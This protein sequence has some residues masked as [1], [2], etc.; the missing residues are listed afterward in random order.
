[1]TKR[2]IVFGVAVWAAALHVVA[3]TEA[4]MDG[5]GGATVS[6]VQDIAG[7]NSWPM[8][9][10]VGGKLVCA[11]SR[12]SAHTIDEGR[13]GVF[14]RVSSDGGK[15]WG[16]EVCVANDPS[17]GEV[18]IGKGLD[19][20]GAMLLWVRRWGKKCGHDLYRTTDGAAFE[21]IATPTLDPM[22]M[23]ITDVFPV[24]GVGLLSLWF[25]GNYQNGPHSSWG[26]LTS[27]DD[28]RTWTQRTIEKDLEKTDWP[29]EQAGVWLGNGRILVVARSEGAGHQFQ[30]TSTDS[31]ATWKRTK[32][33]IT[34][35]NASTPSLI[36]DSNTGR[37]VNY[38]Y[39]RGA[40]K[41]KRRMVDAA[42]IFDHPMEWPEPETLAEGYEK[43][44]WDA[45]NVNA[46][47]LD[48]RHF[49]ATYTGTEHDTSVMVIA[50]PPEKHVPLFAPDR[51]TVIN[52][53][54]FSPG[55]EE[56][57]GTAPL[58]RPREDEEM[59]ANL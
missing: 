54:P 4:R 58:R 47:V 38:Y 28:G 20:T 11:Y 16:A 30:I 53:A 46:T 29:T 51:F 5:V 34:D 42:Y 14:A 13:R 44:A 19:S 50:V 26:I 37:L 57:K 56:L 48:G 23:Q 52:I 17:V 49:L 8:I 25:A 15:T 33:N 24:P 7:Y 31:G 39:H 27:K 18:T 3:G 43:R 12:G 6:V 32:T 2:M 9:Q 22:P 21:K 36:L 55:S 1:M 45:G 41:M 10:A 35:V 59:L 40:R